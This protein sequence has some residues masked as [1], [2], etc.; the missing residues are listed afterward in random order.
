MQKVI[1]QYLR[2]GGKAAKSKDV[3]LLR[4]E[5]SIKWYK[6]LDIDFLA[7]ESRVDRLANRPLKDGPNCRKTG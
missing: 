1:Q 6:N 3:V 5:C 2:K 7:A 4:I